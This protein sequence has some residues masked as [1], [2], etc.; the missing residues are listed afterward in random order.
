MS[1]KISNKQ[2]HN[3]GWED[4][5]WYGTKSTQKEPLPQR[6]ESAPKAASLVLLTGLTISKRQMFLC[7]VLSHA[8]LFETPWTVARQALCSWDCPGKNTE[9]VAMP[10]SRGS[11]HPRDRTEA[12]CMAG[13]FLPSW[14]TKEAPNVS[15]RYEHDRDKQIQNPKVTVWWSSFYCPSRS[16]VGG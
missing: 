14:A 4:T 5:S 13:A 1:L 16:T 7:C 10:S 11:S 6:I 2:L 9:V 3:N 8:R 15:N 12:S